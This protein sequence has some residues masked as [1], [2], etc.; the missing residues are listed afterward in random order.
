MVYSSRQTGNKLYLGNKMAGKPF[1][2]T[3]WFDAAQVSLLAIPYVGVV[4]NPADHNR[5]T[6][7]DPMKCPNGTPEES[8]SAGFSVR[9][10]LAADAAWIAAESDALIVGPEWNTSPGT[11]FEI[12]FHQALRLP[13]WELEIFLTYYNG[14]EDHLYSLKL[15]PIMEIGRAI[16][17]GE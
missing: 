10:A 6:G 2:N 8:R 16:R 11:I 13:C 3:P 14:S 4:F 1:F 9:D 5:K 15:P 17:V 12:A 7:F